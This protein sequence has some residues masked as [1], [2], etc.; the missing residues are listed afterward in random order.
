MTMAVA[1]SKVA[2]EDLVY[3]LEGSLLEACSCE[4]LC[5]CWIG[6]DPDGGSCDAFVAYH[7]DA[8][9]INGVDIGGAKS[10]ERREDPGQRSR[11]W[12]VES[13]HLCR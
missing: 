11:P 12:I 2:S 6:E 4:V 8:G 1:Q 5:P 13:R 10:R 9:T 7:F 3:E